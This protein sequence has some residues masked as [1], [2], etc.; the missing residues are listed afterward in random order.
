[1]IKG[2]LLMVIV[3]SSL[4]LVGCA[5]DQATPPPTEVPT[6]APTPSNTD[7]TDEPVFADA[8]GFTAEEALLILDSIDESSGP[9]TLDDLTADVIC[10]AAAGAWEPVLVF[11]EAV[12]DP[13]ARAAIKGFCAAR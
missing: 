7:P 10:L 1:M 6:P 12:P 2:I 9:D 11:K 8:A 4:A 3:M 5:A 13:G